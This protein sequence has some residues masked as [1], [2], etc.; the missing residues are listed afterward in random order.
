MHHR[1]TDY[2]RPSRRPAAA[3]APR[4]CG[5]TARD[6]GGGSRAVDWSGRARVVGPGGPFQH[7]GRAACLHGAGAG[8]PGGNRAVNGGRTAVD[9]RTFLKNSDRYRRRI[10]CCR[11]AGQSEQ[12]AGRATTKHALHPRGRTPNGGSDALTDRTATPAVASHYHFLLGNTHGKPAIKPAHGNSAR[13][14]N[15][16]GLRH[17]HELGYERCRL[18]TTGSAGATVRCEYTVRRNRNP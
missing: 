2:T 6:G 9:H 15:V 18:C 10:G 16:P 17:F 5:A 14:S 12:G 11:A 7:L 4:L 13:D 1:R 8:R 3:C